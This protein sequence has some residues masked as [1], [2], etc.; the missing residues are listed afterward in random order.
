[1]KFG[2]FDV[3]TFDCYG[4]LIDWEDGILRALRP[5]LLAHGLTLRDA[6][7]LERYS[8]IESRVESLVY[9]PYRD[10]LRA[11][12]TTLFRDAG[13][14]P[15]AAE[16]DSLIDSFGDWRPFADTVGALRRLKQQYRLAILSNV[17]DDLFALTARSLEVEFD[18][19]VTAQ[20]VRSYKPSPVIFHAALKQLGTP[21]ERVLHVAQS[22]YHDIA[23]ARSLG[24]ATAWIDRRRGQIGSGATPAAEARPQAVF[25]DLRAL[26]DRVQETTAQ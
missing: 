13:F 24:I 2:D 14:S 16:A 23:T 8:M 1:M 15:T 12:A 19:V 26:A 11:T 17:D 22:L 5:V 20:Q 3:L 6:E 18:L 9:A 10:V 25:A 21:R 4:T 7:I